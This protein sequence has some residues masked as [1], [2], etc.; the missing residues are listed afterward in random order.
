MNTAAPTSPTSSASTEQSQPALLAL[1]GTEATRPWWRRPMPWLLA[2]LLAAGLAG[3]WLWQGRE[4]R[5]A[6]PRFVT[7]PLQRGTIALTVT[8]N[9][10]LQPTRSVS[11]GSELSGTVARVLVDVN[12][13]VKKGQLLVELDTAKLRDQITRSRAA[14]TSAEAAVRQAASAVKAAQLNLQ[15]LEEVQRLSGG[16]VPSAA[17]L[18]VARATLDQAAAAEA[19]NR[20]QVS[21]AR[22]Q[23]STDETNLARLF[24]RFSLLRK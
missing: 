2:A 10:K 3:A 15:R 18:D 16:Q 21:S 22:A 13:Q 4:T 9:G 5:Q 12:D 14:L 6:A 7:E 20:A 19:S 11:I 23:L 17:E 1:L 8:A 24:L